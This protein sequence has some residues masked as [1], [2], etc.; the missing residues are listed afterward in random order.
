MF[1]NITSPSG[2]RHP[3]RCHGHSIGLAIAIGVAAGFIGMATATPAFAAPHMQVRQERVSTA[4]L[5]LAAVSGRASLERKVLRAVR[6]VCTPDDHIARMA[7]RRETDACIRE[8]R[9]VAL[10]SLNSWLA[11]KGLPQSAGL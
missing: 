3:L 5:D 7:I 11:R 2:L 10:A 4:G 9:A 8:T 6:Q 1:L